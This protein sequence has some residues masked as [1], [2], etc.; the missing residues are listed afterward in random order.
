MFI[1]F[2]LV[3]LGAMGFSI[4]LPSIMFVAEDFGGGEAMAGWIV[5]SY[6]IGQLIATPVW[7][8]LS[9]RYG[10]KLI[11]AACSACT[12]IA[13]LGLAFAYDALTLFLSRLAGGLAGGLFSVSQAWVADTTTPRNRAK[14][15]GIMGAG[16]S[17]G[18]ILGPFVG[19]LLGGGSVETASLLQPGLLGAA[20]AAVLLIVILVFMRESLPPEKRMA[21]QPFAAEMRQWGAVSKR[22][23][24]SR[25]LVLGLLWMT[26]AGMF[27][28]MMP[29]WVG[30]KLDWGPR[31]VGA[32]FL[33]LGLLVAVIQGFVAGR[34]S[35]RFGEVPVIGAGIV[36]YAAGLLIIA[37]FGMVAAGP[38]A[39]D[40]LRDAVGALS[41]GDV[42]ADLAGRPWLLLGLGSLAGGSSLLVPNISSLVSKYASVS[43][44]GTVLGLFQ[45]SQ[46]L[47]R[48]VSP[49]IG[50]ALFQEQGANA[51][52]YGSVLVLI[53]C[54]AGLLVWFGGSRA[55][56]HKEVEA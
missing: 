23:A 20:L 32:Q 19:G 49:P 2:A 1:I 29:L 11:L 42:L 46:W 18:F 5:A 9:D 15:M 40:P 54:L 24:V 52:L 16:I 27:E 6:A 44:R 22:P 33:Y 4:V 48:T 3:L 56:P 53:P 37:N 30:D 47:G 26:A 35:Q 12:M 28:V 31:H 55:Q 45:S 38:F 39:P 25:L 51:P 8:R 13:F 41:M 21:A 17:L 10:R 50:G 7:G 36:F 34:L 43:E 14:G